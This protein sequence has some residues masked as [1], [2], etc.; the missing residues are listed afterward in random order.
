M[1]NAD[2]DDPQP[3]GAIVLILGNDRKRQRAKASL[4]DDKGAVAAIIA[5]TRGTRRPVPERAKELPTLPVRIEGEDASGLGSD[6]NLLEAS[7]EAAA[8][9]KALPENTTLT[10]DGPSTSDKKYTGMRSASCAAAIRAC[11][12]PRCCSRPIWITWE[13]VRR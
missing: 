3:A 4:L 10:F 7:P 2:E 1:I 9:L 8:I 6:F 12:K 5:A 13:L 11:N